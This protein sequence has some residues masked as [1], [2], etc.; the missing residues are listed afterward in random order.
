MKFCRALNQGFASLA[1]DRAAGP[2][3]FAYVD[4]GSERRRAS[5][6]LWETYKSP[7]IDIPPLTEQNWRTRA[8][9]PRTTTR[10][11]SPVTSWRAA[12]RLIVGGTW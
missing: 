11:T 10:P 7:V 3:A 8:G 9:S 1:K 12:R 4:I 6:S 5:A 2:K